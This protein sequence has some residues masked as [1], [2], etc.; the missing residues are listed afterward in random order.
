VHPSFEFVRELVSNE[1]PRARSDLRRRWEAGDP[2]VLLVTAPQRVGPEHLNQTAAF[3]LSL[4][5]GT[6]SLPVI[7]EEFRRRFPDLEEQRA[8]VESIRCVRALQRKGL[9][10]RLEETLGSRVTAKQR[11][12]DKP[13]GEGR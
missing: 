6:R 2:P 7:A 12:A 4:C 1:F 5:D 3:I 9:L 13:A 11:V 8:F 10:H